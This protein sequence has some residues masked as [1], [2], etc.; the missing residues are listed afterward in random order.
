MSSF[1]WSTAVISLTQTALIPADSKALA[2]ELANGWLSNL[3]EATGDVFITPFSSDT[4]EI[5]TQPSIIV[6]S[7]S[8]TC[9]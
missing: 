6:R 5:F 2:T 9:T 8:M 1:P 7:M 4:T 3:I